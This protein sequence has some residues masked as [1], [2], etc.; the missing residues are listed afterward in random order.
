MSRLPVQEVDRFSKLLG[1]L[2]SDQHGERAV[3]AAKATQ[4]LVQRG[5]HW[6]DIA[7]Q[8]R[9]PAVAHKASAVRDHQQNALKCLAAGVPWK[10]HE[11]EFLL[12]MTIQIRRPTV[13]QRDW[14]DALLD[15][16]SHQREASDER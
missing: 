14:L 9:G 11:R 13:K 12:H 7:N 2:A 8:L 15:R 16:A 6:S 10:P 1:L 4:F 5:L 3:A